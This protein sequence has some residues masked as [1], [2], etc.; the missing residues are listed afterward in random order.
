MLSPRPYA[1]AAGGIG[2]LLVLL[3]ATVM[4]GW[5]LH[6]PWA[7]TLGNPELAVVFSTA[8]AL[9]LLGTGVAALSA[10][11]L[12][13]ALADRTGS[14]TAAC[15]STAAVL[16]A[17]RVVEAATGWPVAFDIPDLHRWLDH[18]WLTG[19]VGAPQPSHALALGLTGLALALAPDLT[20]RRRA[21]VFYG[22]LALSLLTSG[23]DLLGQAMDLEYLYPTWLKWRASNVTAV[24]SLL[25]VMAVGCAARARHPGLWQTRL[26]PEDTIV[27]ISGGCVVLAGLCA[28]ITAFILQIENANATF[29]ITRAQALASYAEEFDQALTTRVASPRLIVATLRV[30][31]ALRHP[32]TTRHACAASPRSMRTAS[33]ATPTWRCARRPAKPCSS[34][35]PRSPIP[36]SPSRCVR[37]SPRNGPRCNGS[38]ASACVPKRRS[39]STVHASVGSSP[40]NRWRR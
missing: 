25:A 22:L 15:G 20:Q 30:Q 18:Q 12:V 38:T 11:S 14:A 26:S 35:G 37:A 32:P 9:A 33:R 8:F 36:S 28:T 3:A 34:W 6:W 19:W 7:V 40:N 21:I 29:G 13:P 31:D 23:I 2:L 4:G 27:W 10:G 16:C 24:C 17:L 5:L 39:W 1:A